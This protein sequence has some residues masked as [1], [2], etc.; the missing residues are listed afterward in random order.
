MK[1]TIGMKSL[2]IVEAVYPEPVCHDDQENDALWRA[3]QR[4]MLRPLP[5]RDQKILGLSQWA[6]KNGRCV[7]FACQS[8][9][10]YRHTKECPIGV[11]LL[12][13]FPTL[14]WSDFLKR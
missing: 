13:I 11:V 10:F 4:E 8:D 14:E 9:D 6:R 5:L 1:E 2:G 7:H 3:F 12:A